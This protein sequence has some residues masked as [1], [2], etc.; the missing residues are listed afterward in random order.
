MR[1]SPG[2][3]EIDTSM[4]SAR[5][6][7]IVSGL[8]VLLLGQVACYPSLGDLVGRKLLGETGGLEP[9][10]VAFQFL[11]VLPAAL[12]F[13][14]AASWGMLAAGQRSSRLFWLA[15]T[16]VIIVDLALLVISVKLYF[17]GSAV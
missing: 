4:D 1:F 11:R 14:G 9:G 5:A 17:Q 12:V 3:R 2:A 8:A 7:W 16:F 10:I 15:V 13:T 6:R